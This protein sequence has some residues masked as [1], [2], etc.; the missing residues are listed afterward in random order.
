M[1]IPRGF[2]RQGHFTVKVVDGRLSYQVGWSHSRA[3]R[4]SDFRRL[5]NKPK[6]LQVRRTN[7]K[8]ATKV[9][10]DGEFGLGPR[11]AQCNEVLMD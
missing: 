7:R 6:S 9:G 10:L 5:R 4:G 11:Q 2:G 8:V 1:A 3:E